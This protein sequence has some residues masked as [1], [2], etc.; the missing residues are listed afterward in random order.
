MDITT[1]L[2]TELITDL[3]AQEALS[4]TTWTAAHSE[5]DLSI[6]THT[7]AD[8]ALWRVSTTMPV[9]PATVAAGLRHLLRN[10][11]DGDQLVPSITVPRSRRDH[12]EMTPRSRRDDDQLVPS[13]TVR[14]PVAAGWFPHS[15]S[16]SEG[17]PTARTARGR[18]LPYTAASV[19]G[20]C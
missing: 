10:W 19:F 7:R 8:R 14:T 18:H 6:H 20:R 1:D 5:G 11:G 4:S 2:I 3:M 12:A 9:P 13:S 17:L 15:L 16:N